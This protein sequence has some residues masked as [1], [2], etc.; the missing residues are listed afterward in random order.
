MNTTIGAYVPTNSFFHR[1]DP[2]LKLFAVVA[3]IVCVFLDYGSWA[4]TFACNGALFLIGFLTMLMSGISPSSILRSLKGLIV[5]VVFLLII[6]VFFPPMSSISDPGWIAFKI[7]DINVYWESIL[8][9]LKILLRLVTMFTYTIILTGTTRPLDLNF[10]MEWYMSP[11]KLIKVPVHIF[12]MMMS[13]ALR[14]IPTLLDETKQLMRAQSSRGLDYNKGSIAT[15]FRGIVALIVPLFVSAFTRSTELANAMIAR[16][17]DPYAK[18]TRY[19]TLSFA[20]RDLFVLLYVL[21][22][23]AGFILLRV[24]F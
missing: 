2:R 13:L 24:M 11:L 15:K 4:L 5:L 17:Y 22:A 10:S 19:R 7:G 6:N 14:F 18:R 16:G 23:L 20:W 12:S 1:V 3:F 9:T 8:Q 21:M